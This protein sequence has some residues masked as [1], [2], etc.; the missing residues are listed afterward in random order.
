MSQVNSNTEHHYCISKL[1]VDAWQALF[2]F[3]FF[4][5]FPLGRDHGAGVLRITSTP[6][7]NPR[8]LRSR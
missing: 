2:P 3:I 5:Y 7:L 8:A 4:A 1:G 6:L